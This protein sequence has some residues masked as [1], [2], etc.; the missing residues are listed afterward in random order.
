ML[1]GNVEVV[2][3][4]RRRLLNE[5]IGGHWVAD[6]KH[7]QECPSLMLGLSGTGYF[8]LR[9]ALSDRVPSVLNLD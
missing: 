8:L 2:R 3:D 5:I 7:T 4:W 9:A 1:I 6:I